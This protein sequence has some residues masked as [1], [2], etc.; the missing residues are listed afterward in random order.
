[1]PLQIENLEKRINSIRIKPFHTILFCKFRTHP[2]LFEEL[3]KGLLLI[4][5]VK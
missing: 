3:E 1:M 5:L 4:Y 2:V